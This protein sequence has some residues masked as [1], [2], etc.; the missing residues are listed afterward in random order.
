M[1][2][3]INVHN[4]TITAIIHVCAQQLGYNI[5]YIV[6]GVSLDLEDSLYKPDAPNIN[7]PDALKTTT[8]HLH[9]H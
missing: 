3:Q 6:R 4:T 9:T 8:I 2:S 1:S 7:K 5:I